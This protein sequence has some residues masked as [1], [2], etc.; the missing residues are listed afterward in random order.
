M[1]NG[2]EDLRAHGLIDARDEWVTAGLSAIGRI[3]KVHDSLR[4]PFTRAERHA[5]QETA[6]TATKK[7]EA[8]AQKKNKRVKRPATQETEAARPA[9]EA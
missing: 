4:T 5:L 7:R 3:K 6:R 9:A 2:L 8:A 1:Q